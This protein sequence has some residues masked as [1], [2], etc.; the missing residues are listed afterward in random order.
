MRILILVDDYFPSTKSAAKM[1]HDLGS[2]LS[3]EGHHV[4]VVTPSDKAV[5]PPK[6]SLEDGIHVLRVRA[7]NLKQ[8][9]RPM[10]G[11]R[12]SRL[13]ATI[14]RNAREYFLANSFDLI[15]FYSP[16]IFFGALVRKLK[17]LW[18]C[19]AYLVLRDIF[20]KW[21]VEAGVLRRDGALH[22]Y[23]RGKELLQYSVADW[24]GVE[25]SGNL[26]YFQNDLGNRYPAEVLF[27]W[28]ELDPPQKSTCYRQQMNLEGK[29]VF[30]YGGNIGVAQDMDNIVRLA[31][32]L[33]EEPK[34][35]FLL[36]GEGS[37]A[38]RLQA[39]I[40]ERGLANMRILPPVPQGEYLQMLSEFDVGLVTLDRRLSSH[41]L[42]GKIF[43]Y[44]NNALPILA[45]V[46]PGN[47]LATLLRE[48]NAGIACENGD[49][50]C[51]REAA[52]RLATD[53][54][55]RMLMGRNSRSLLTNKFSVAVAALQ[56]LSHVQSS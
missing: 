44:M 54:E 15:I 40:A 43:G 18:N 6:I 30:F 9:F 38:P 37:E 20:P 19:P 7:G 3:R 28:M 42:P 46:N 23:F 49:D 16:T 31:A 27:S 4:S 1:I 24:I 34:I 39:Q 26:E 32:S 17:R 55:T 8:T 22:R 10:R 45:S 13:S 2:W 52:L 14:W 53:C 35:F 47:D 11:W 50:P 29:T 48:S 41:N 5:K 56:I 33:R 51:L 36:V 21:A 12:E 25:A